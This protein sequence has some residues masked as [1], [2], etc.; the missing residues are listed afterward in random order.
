VQ[1]Q[2]Q[3]LERLPVPVL[4]LLDFLDSDRVDFCESI[5][6]DW[7]HQLN[8]QSMRQTRRTIEDKHRTQ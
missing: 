4:L 7:Q 5:E 3:T 1:V 6:N 8:R 2:V